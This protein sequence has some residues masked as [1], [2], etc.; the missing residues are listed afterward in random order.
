MSPKTYYN[1][2]YVLIHIWDENNF[3]RVI[4]EP[5]NLFKGSIS[6]KP[7]IVTLFQRE[8]SFYGLL[9]IQIVPKTYYNILSV[10]ILI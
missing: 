2:L 5:K 1:I 7:V 8:V 3:V 4:W 9:E 10:E 6:A